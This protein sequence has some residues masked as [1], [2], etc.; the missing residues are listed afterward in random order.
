MM[1]KFREANENA[2]HDRKCLG[3]FGEV[4][5]MGYKTWFQISRKSYHRM[6]R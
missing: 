5:E 3:H 1:L 2:Q 4:N 6:S